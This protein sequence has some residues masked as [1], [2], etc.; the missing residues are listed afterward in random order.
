ME[1][2][3][4]RIKSH[5]MHEAGYMANI[6]NGLYMLLNVHFHSF[7]STRFFQIVLPCCF[8]KETSRCTLSLAINSHH[9]TV[10]DSSINR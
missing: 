6:D 7:Y 5:N 2:E 3:K 10:I 4:T 9:I 1:I 8:L